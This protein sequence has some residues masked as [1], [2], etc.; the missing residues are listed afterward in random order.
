MCSRTDGVPGR[1]QGI[2]VMLSASW[3]FTRAVNTLRCI[4]TTKKKKSIAFSTHKFLQLCQIGLV[5]VERIH[6]C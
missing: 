3:S 6:T 4:D 2:A 1:A 5:Q